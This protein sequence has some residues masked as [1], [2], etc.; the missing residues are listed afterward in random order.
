MRCAGIKV[1]TPPE[2]LPVTQG[3][4]VE[5]ARINGITVQVQ[6]A[7]LDRQLSAA[8]WRAEVFMRR[9]ILTQT[10]EGTFTS[11]GSDCA[12]ALQL[13]LPRGDVQSVT[14]VT[15]GQG[16][17]ITGYTL[18]GNV[19]TLASPAYYSPVT[20]V[21]VSGYG[22]DAAAVPDTVREGILEYAT[23][24][25]EDRVGAREAKYAAGAHGVPVGVHDLWRSEQIE[26]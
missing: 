24:L 2:G 19:I 26:V 15:D 1:K 8:T 3:E 18:A 14:S 22:D 6:P 4:F 12:C 17:A 10:L 13:T 5:H 20:V 11:D 16:T 23:T 25:Y 9:S 21:W 7:L